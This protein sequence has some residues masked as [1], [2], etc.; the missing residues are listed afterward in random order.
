MSGGDLNQDGDIEDDGE[1]CYP[2]TTGNINVTGPVEDGG[3]N[4]GTIDTYNFDNSGNETLPLPF[5]N[6]NTVALVEAQKSIAN[7]KIYQSIDIIMDRIE[8]FWRN[9]RK[10]HKQNTI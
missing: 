7:R 4:Q 10:Q 3:E 1:R 9:R 2:T 5:K 6:K 8:W